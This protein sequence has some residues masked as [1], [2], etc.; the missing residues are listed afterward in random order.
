MKTIR[1]KKTDLLKKLTQNR[2]KHEREHKLAM[3]GFFKKQ[4]SA[5]GKYLAKAKRGKVVG[6]FNMPRPPVYLEEYDRVIAMLRM[7]V[8]TE[9]ELTEDEFAKYAQDQWAWRDAFM[10]VSNSYLGRKLK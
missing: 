4:I 8:E 2:A 10:T 5:L 9:I 7:S 1:V 3:T 6:H